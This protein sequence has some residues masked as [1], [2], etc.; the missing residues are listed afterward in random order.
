MVNL[1]KTGPQEIDSVPT[2]MPPIKDE[3]GYDV[4]NH[5]STYVAYM[6]RQAKE[7]IGGQPLLPRKPSYDHD[8]QLNKIDRQYAV[9]Q[10]G[11]VGNFQP[12]MIRSRIKQ[13]AKTA[14]IIGSIGL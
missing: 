9:V 8:N 4:G 13:Q 10:V 1:V 7:G 6:I 11:T 12:G 3:G 2:A 5:S 14:K